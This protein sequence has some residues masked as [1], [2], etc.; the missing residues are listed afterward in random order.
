MHCLSDSRCDSAFNAVEMDGSLRGREANS[1]WFNLFNAVASQAA[2]GAP[3]ILLANSLHASSLFLG[4]ITAL[5][6]LGTM[7]QL[8]TARLLHV[9]EYRTTF[10]VGWL[11]RTVFIFLVAL[12]P[13]PPFLDPAAKRGTLLAVLVTF[14]VLRGIAT[15]AWW[16]WIAELIPEERRA[17][18][19]ARDQLFT[20]IGGVFALAA[21]GAVMSE[22]SSATEFARTFLVGGIC[23]VVSLG[24]LK[25]MPNPPASRRA[26][27]PGAPVNWREVLAKRSFTQLIGLN[28]LLL[29]VIGSLNVFAIQFLRDVCDFS[30]ESIL[31]LSAVMFLGPL[32]TLHFLGNWTDRRGPGLPLLGVLGTYGIVVTGWLL[33]A[34]GVLPCAPGLIA[35]LQVLAGTASAAFNVANMHLALKVIPEVGRNRLL[36]LFTVVTSLSLAGAPVLFGWLLDAIGNR[37]FVFAGQVFQ[38]HAVYFGILFLLVG[39]AFA[40]AVF[41]LPDRSGRERNGL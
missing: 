29:L 39:I 24:F 34:L 18:F 17:R 31:Y 27:E 19:L 1:H 6:P 2:M 33:I 41:W 35:V 12:L 21:Y 20:Y 22:N 3:I 5:S 26:R 23:G 11:L 36:A 40:V 28:V 10:F 8:P 25:R 4:I 30:A 13:L 16:P 9:S 14:N 37:H 32:L 7:L 15:A 38:R